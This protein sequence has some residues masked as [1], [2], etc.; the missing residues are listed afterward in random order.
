[1]CEASNRLCEK[2]LHTLLHRAQSGLRRRIQV[3]YV[4]GWQE[5]ALVAKEVAREWSESMPVITRDRASLFAK[6]IRL[7]QQF[8]RARD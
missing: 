4:K 1:M 5:I 2:K 6:I 7:R 3:R 8:P